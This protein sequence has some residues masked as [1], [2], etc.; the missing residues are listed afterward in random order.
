ME[1]PDDNVA[2]ESI[3]AAVR[4]NDL[5]RAATAP[6][7][8][9]LFEVLRRL[10][11]R[12][13][14]SRVFRGLGPETLR[15][16]VRSMKENLS[17]FDL[18]DDVLPDNE[19]TNNELSRDEP[20]DL[21]ADRDAEGRGPNASEQSRNVAAAS[22]ARAICEIHEKPVRLAKKTSKHWD[23]LNRE[24]RTDVLRIL[25]AYEATLSQMISTFDDLGG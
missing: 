12:A 23:R 5:P 4:D 13:E 24:V 15:V 11:T 25:L 22:M 8:S 14:L 6:S 10:P 19:P 3:R 16:A 1:I 2:Q 21:P 17:A 7:R 20:T 18:G 9:D